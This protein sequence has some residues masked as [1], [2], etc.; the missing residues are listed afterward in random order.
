MTPQEVAD[1]YERSGYDFIAF[2]DHDYLM[3]PH[4]ENMYL[5]V[6]TNLLIFIGIELTVFVKGYIHVNKIQ[7]DA[8]VLHIFNHIGEY[9]LSEAQIYNRL[10]E[11][12]KMYPIDAVEVTAKG[13]RMSECENMDIKYPKIATDDSH[14][15]LGIGRAWIELSAPKNK[16]E[17]IRSI[18]HGDFWNGFL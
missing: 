11:L 16:D 4:F 2:T 13:F 18:K 10:E 9:Q 6:K 12:E 14:D 15:L 17:I 5:S 7:G 1:A 8:E 3:K